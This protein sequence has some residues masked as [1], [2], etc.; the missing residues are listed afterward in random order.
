MVAVSYYSAISLYSGYGFMSLVDP[1]RIIV[2]MPNWVG[3]LVMATAV[4]RDLREKF[5]S[6]EI[7]AMVLS[8]LAPLLVGNPYLNDIFTFTKMNAF[9]RRQEQR[10]LVARIQ[11]GKYDLG[12]LLTHSLSSA[13]WFWRGDV[14]MRI[15]YATHM[16][17]WLLTRAVPLPSTL[18]HEHLVITYKRLLGALDIP[19][20]NAAP[21]LFVTPE[22][23]ELARRL[24]AKQASEQ[25]MVHNE[26]VLYIGMNPSAA[27]GPAKEWPEERFSRLAE[28]LL[29]Q[30]PRARVV[31]F[32]DPAGAPRV[33]RLVAA[34]RPELRERILNL[35]GRT[36][37]REL[38]SLIALMD[39]FITC[40]SG[41]M[42]IAAA[43]GT[44]LIA[45]F[46]STSEVVT[47]PY[48]ASSSCGTAQSSASK[49]A[50]PAAPPA[51]VIR[52][53]VPCAPC[54]LRTCPIDFRCMRSIEVSEVAQRAAEILALH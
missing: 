26:D 24:L 29:S 51:L 12:L 17:S 44:P 36:S 9:L 28:S 53:Q 49:R 46:G 2:R 23:R 19:L 22:E 11:Q 48:R 16:R 34:I 31:F 21:E 54:F 33:D 41:P 47:G 43:L 30:Q 39:L 14:R 50:P 45:L 27:Y 8:T 25:K 1:Q 5:P 18:G 7:T 13:I 35:A 15:G 3:D 42:H 32:G 10:D 40:D 37:L 4:L 20:S 52:K 6:A 38:V